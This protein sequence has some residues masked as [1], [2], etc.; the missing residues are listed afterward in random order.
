MRATVMLISPRVYVEN[1][2]EVLSGGLGDLC[3]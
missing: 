3:A 2:I 1:L